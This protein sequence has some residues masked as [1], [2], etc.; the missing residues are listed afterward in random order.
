MD[1]DGARLEEPSYHSKSFFCV[2]GFTRENIEVSFS[3]V[4]SEVAC[5][6]TR[7]DELHK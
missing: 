4:F 6:G 1:F 3:G 7:L 2:D 5:N